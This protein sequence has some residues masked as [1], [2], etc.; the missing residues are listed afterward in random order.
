MRA[1]CGVDP[2]GDTVPWAISQPRRTRM[3]RPAHRRF[4]DCPRA[5]GQALGQGAEPTGAAGGSLTSRA[6]VA[7][8]LP[9]PMLPWALCRRVLPFLGCMRL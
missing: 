3:G 8:F 7:L 1:T 4:R 5:T 6:H 2:P 9:T